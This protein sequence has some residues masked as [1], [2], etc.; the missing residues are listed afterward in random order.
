MTLSN[1]KQIRCLRLF[2]YYSELNFP[3]VQIYGLVKVMA[4]PI[5]YKTNRLHKTVLLFKTQ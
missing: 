1:S 3:L 2:L 4:S 5:N